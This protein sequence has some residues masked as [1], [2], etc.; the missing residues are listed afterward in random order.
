MEIYIDHLKFGQDLRQQQGFSFNEVEDGFTFLRDHKPARNLLKIV[1]LARALMYSHDAYV[2]AARGGVDFIKLVIA[3]RFLQHQTLSTKSKGTLLYRLCRLGLLMA[4]CESLEPFPKIRAYHA[5]SSRQMMLLIDECDKLGYWGSHPD[6][7]LWVTILGGYTARTSSLQWWFA[8]QL[9][10]SRV[11]V[12]KE[13]WPDARRV[14][15]RFVAVT[16][17]QEQGCHEFWDG[18]C[19]WISRK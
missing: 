2:E 7:L 9:R 5:F 11:P 17:R 1:P 10:S 19:T 6:L 4:L 14:C 3:R 18:S 13:R 12:V 15:E 8:E 16:Y